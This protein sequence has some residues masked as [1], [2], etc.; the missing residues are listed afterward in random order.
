MVRLILELNVQFN[1]VQSRETE[2][3]LL[4]NIC[5]IRSGKKLSQRYGN[6]HILNIQQNINC[7]LTTELMLIHKY[8]SLL[9]PFY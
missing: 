2:F 8:F 4:L 3:N 1:L 7:K 5:K 6:V 9:Y